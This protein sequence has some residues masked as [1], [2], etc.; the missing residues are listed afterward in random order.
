MVTSQD[1]EAMLPR[2]R[3]LIGSKFA[4]VPA[5]IDR[6]DMLQEAM[7]ALCKARH[8]Y[9]PAKGASWPTY[10]TNRAYGAI[11]DYLREQTPG[12]RGQTHLHPLSLDEQWDI[13][14]GY[15]A[16]TDFFAVD[17]PEPTDH[18]HLRI[19]QA[20]I[21]KLPHAEARAVRFYAGGYTMAEIAELEFV[22]ESRISQRITAARQ[23][24]TKILPA[25][26][27][28][29]RRG[30]LLVDRTAHPDKQAAILAANDVHPG[31]TIV[32]LAKRKVRDGRVCSTQGRAKANGSL[33]RPV[34]AVEIAA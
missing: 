5:H 32:S 19:L 30:T 34:W 16:I 14:D 29:P 6:D 17:D 27:A 15:T 3:A 9:D 8:R 25:M 2:V 31:C 1:V 7:S 22:T 13:D 24:L 23:R 11:R 12:K 28:P 33:G 18:A 20:A 10:A 21:D 26:T 4:Q